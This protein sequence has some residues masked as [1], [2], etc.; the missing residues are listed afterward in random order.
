MYESEFKLQ[1]QVKCDKTKM[2]EDLYIVGDGKE[3]GDWKI[4]N[5]QQKL[6]G[7]KYP[8]WQS[9]FISF[10]KKYL[11]FKYVIKKDHNL[12]WE[13]Q[14]IGNRKLDLSNLKDGLYLIDDG[15]FDDYQNPN[16]QKI[17]NLIKN[18]DENDENDEIDE[19]DENEKDK[20]KMDN[21]KKS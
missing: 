7:N 13:R 2:G 5:S 14:K 12:V 11:E 15:N 19:N 10:N 4:E 8:I 18:E 16:N 1:F 20:C 9:E 21:N 3:F 17:I 6:Y